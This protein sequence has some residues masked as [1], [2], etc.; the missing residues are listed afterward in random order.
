[1][2]GYLDK[3]PHFTLACTILLNAGQI[4]ADAAGTL[5]QWIT[6]LEKSKSAAEHVIWTEGQAE[7]PEV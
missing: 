3:Q 5:G 2:T 4:P 7:H 1:M 6:Y